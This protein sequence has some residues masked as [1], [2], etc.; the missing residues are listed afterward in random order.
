MT[1]R[2][3][4]SA[5]GRIVRS[6]WFLLVARFVVAGAA[7]AAVAWRVGAGPFLH[8][9]LSL[10]PGVVVAA[11]ALAFV[12]TA[13]AAWRWRL[14]ARGL[15][16]EVSWPR[17][18]GMYYRSQ[19]LNTVLPGGV[20]GDVHRAVDHGRSTERPGRAAQAVAGERIAGQLVQLVITVA[21]LLVAGAA[22]GGVLFPAIGGVLAAVTV[23]LTAA[24]LLSARM[25]RLLRAGV[26]R[27]RT[28]RRAAIALAQ[29][30]VASVVV[31]ACHVATVVVASAA[32]GVRLQPDRMLTLAVVVLCA[33]SIP[34]NIGGWGPREGVAAWAFAVG[35]STASLGVSAATLVGVLAVVSVVPG[36][37]AAALVPLIVR[38]TSRVRASL[39][40][41]QLRHLP[42]R[43]PRLG[44]PA[45]AGAVERGGLRPGG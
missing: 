43:V 42:R 40:D 44:R 7:L 2:E 27:L 4:T 8:G 20:L 35:G 31:V 9:L 38:R 32:V 6:R 26:H 33:A 5:A 15:G 10:R 18:V 25:R 41:R 1:V 37:L 45:A 23:A 30:A 21:V 13:A 36:V 17:A 12:A 19:F 3:V 24:A 34:V 16:I 11:V 28:D 14:V 39:R 29:I 22:F